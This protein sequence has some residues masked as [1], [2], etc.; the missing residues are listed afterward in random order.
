LVISLV[1]DSGCFDTLEGAR[2]FGEA[3]DPDVVWDDRFLPE[4]IKGRGAVVEHLERMSLRHSRRR[5][6]IDRVSDG[7]EACGYCW[8]WTSGGL[9]GLRGTTFVQ[10]NKAT[11]KIK[12]VQEIPEPL[13][14]PG[15]LTKDLLQALTRGAELKMPQPFT[16]R[17]PTA[18]S[19]V[20]R[21]LFVDLQGAGD[22]SSLKELT[23]L[24]DPRIQYRDFNYDE[25]MVGPHQVETFVRDFTFPGIEFRPTRFDDGIDSTCFTWEVV[26][27]GVDSDQTIKGISFYELDP[28][29]RKISYIRDVPESSLKPPVLG[30]LARFLRPGLGVFVPV[31]IGSRPGGM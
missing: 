12:F 25:M 18:A 26:L 8:T 7:D 31:P 13:F 5:I 15:D 21:Y 6:R 24:L 23:R 2:L 19:D 3:C 4:P 1:R 30:N 10:L 11:D 16:V 17:T 20:A 22:E 29:T 9:E 28:A 27:Q 14:K